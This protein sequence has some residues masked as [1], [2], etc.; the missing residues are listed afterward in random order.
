VSLQTND[1]KNYL[2]LKAVINQGKFEIQGEA[3]VTVASLL[4]W[5]DKL[6]PKFKS[7]EINKPII[8]KDVIKKDSKA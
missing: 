7:N 5:Y 3:I 8:K 2:A 1:Y 6:E 4:S